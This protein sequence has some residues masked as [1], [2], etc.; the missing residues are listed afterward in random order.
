MPEPDEDEQLRSVGLQNAKSILQARQRLEQQ[1][2]D[3]LAAAR[4]LAAIVESSSDAILSKSLDGTIQSWNT[5]AQH[6]FGYTA[7]E[8]IGQHISFII[9]ADRADEET[10]IVERLRAG[11]QI[12]HYETV[13]LRKDGLHV[14]VSLT[15]SPIRDE[16]G[17]VI[18]ASKIARDIT[19]RKQSE[20]ALRESEQALTDFFD[21]ATVG[22]HWMGPDG[23]ILRVNQMELDL[24]GY[25][26]DEYLGQHI[27]KFHADAENI[28]DILVRLTSGESISGRDARLL[29]K[30][31][32]IKHVLISSN[33]L[34]RDG[35][36]IHSRCFT[37][38]V[39]AHKQAQ[40]ALLYSEQLH[41][42][43]FDLAPTGIAY[44]GLDERFIKVNDAMCDITGYSAEELLQMTAADLTHP[45]DLSHDTNLLDTNLL[46]AFLCGGLQQYAN[47]KR[48]IC[49][50]GGIRWVS[51][52]GRMVTDE[53]GQP[54]HSICVIRD[55]TERRAS[56]EAL[57]TSEARFRTA[58]GAVSSLIW[59]NSPDGLMSGE[60]PGW[61]DFT[62]QTYDEYQGYGWSQAV[63]PDDAQETI[64][65]W[66]H[67]VAKKTSFV[68][69][70]R[71]RRRDGPWRLCSIKAVPVLNDKGEIQEW[72]GVHTDITT[73]REY[74]N[75]LRDS[76]QRMRLATEATAIGIWEW[77]LVTDE[78]KWTPQ[79]FV[80]M[81]CHQPQMDLFPIKH[82]P[83]WSCPRTC[84]NRKRSCRRLC[85]N[86]VAAVG[87]FAF[88]D[89][90]IG[91]AAK[92][93]RSK[94]FA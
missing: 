44:L 51:V 60:Q 94:R 16:T 9:P 24:L 17:K 88:E 12:A 56:E 67:A 63:H 43:A 25:D 86:A 66:K 61:A 41:R 10:Y 28:N 29:C 39:T 2:R 7:E 18:G 30:D 35:T 50:N 6:L 45:D 52:V 79:C 65:A 11:G 4:F 46:D 64:V 54:L 42:I 13:R 76:D 49:M 15:V 1:V 89:K 91:S 19:D 93:P 5:G 58:V 3:Q 59:T 82:G 55:V 33:G 32:S 84:P 72:V 26:R 53:P 62:G 78:I 37:R 8:A 69:Q 40:A 80:S 22:L 48:W 27:A 81:G 14:D 23:I 20:T 70:H 74:E 57:R 77:N 36:F 92:S 21:N 68:F 85:A 75:A 73:Q 38:D 83:S 34:F 87:S 47:E 90:T 31:G 71:V